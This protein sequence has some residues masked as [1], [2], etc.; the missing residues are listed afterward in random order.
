MSRA[1]TFLAPRASGRAADEEPGTRNE[2]HLPD[3]PRPPHTW[4]PEAMTMSMHTES[5]T[6]E[7]LERKPREDEIDFYGLTH[8]GKVRKNNNDHFLLASLHKRME[9]RLTSLPGL[10]HE[11]Q[12]SDQRLAFI[13]MVADGVGG[14]EGG[15]EA[16]RI[17]LA[18]VTEFLANSLQAYYSSPDAREEAFRDTLQKAATESHNTV[19]QRAAERTDSRKRATTLTIWMGVWP[20]AYVLQ[21]GDSRYYIYRDGVLTQVTRD[22]TYAEDLVDAGALSRDQAKDSPL[23][24]VLS[25]AIGGHETFPVVTRLTSHWKNVHLMCSDGLTK[26]VTDEQIK[27]RLEAMTSAKET[28][29]LLLQDALDG[30]GTDNITIIV[31]RAIKKD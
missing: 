22:Q 10:E 24:N 13:G 15:E 11:S 17:A 19:L 16:S 6:A 28:A 5:P 18:N 20:Y 4:H 7:T 14:T 26:H 21:V 12:F 1:R 3:A 25:S 29:E 23:K 31:G 27:A 8:R 2:E 9:V 30:G